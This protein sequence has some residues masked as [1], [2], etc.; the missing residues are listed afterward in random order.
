LIQFAQLFLA[1]LWTSSERLVA[2]LLLSIELHSAA[3]TPV[4]VNGHQI[5]PNKG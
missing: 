4:G 2:E 1:A 5:P 3:L